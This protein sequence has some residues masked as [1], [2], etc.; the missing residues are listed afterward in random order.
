MHAQVRRRRESRGIYGTGGED[1]GDAAQVR[2]VGGYGLHQPRLARAR[3]GVRRRRPPQRGGKQVEEEEEEEEEPP[4]AA[5]RGGWH[6]GRWL[7]RV[8]LNSE[9]VWSVAK[10]SAVELKSWNWRPTVK[11]HR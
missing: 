5:V 2:H 9:R 3:A 7:A 10:P 11:S 6:G 4:P 1:P 8:S